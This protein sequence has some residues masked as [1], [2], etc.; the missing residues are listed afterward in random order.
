[1][2]GGFKVLWPTGVHEEVLILCL[3]AVAYVLKAATLLKVFYP[4]LIHFTCLSYGQQHVAVGV[5]AKFTQENKLI[6]MTK[7]LFLKAPCQVQS[8]KQHLPDMALSPR[9]VQPR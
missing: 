3:D 6:L 8:Y 1:V 7:E 2:N 9:Q 4:N 5:R